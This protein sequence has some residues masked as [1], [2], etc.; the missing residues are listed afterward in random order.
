MNTRSLNNA[1]FVLGKIRVKQVKWNQLIWHKEKLCLWR[2]LC[3]MTCDKWGM[4][5]FW[6]CVLLKFVSMEIESDFQIKEERIDLEDL[7]IP[8]KVN[9]VFETMSCK[10]SKTIC[11]HL[12]KYSL[13]FPNS[14][15]LTHR[16]LSARVNDFENDQQKFKYL[17]LEKY[18]KN[19]NQ[20]IV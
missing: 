2:T 17:L 5:S 1:I 10:E 7:I 4:E 19:V 8:S 6:I 13:Q 3:F 14:Q 20:L 18:G 11:L 16:P 12:Q 15:F 9:R